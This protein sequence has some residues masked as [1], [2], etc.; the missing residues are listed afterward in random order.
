MLTE[1]LWQLL[2][3]VVFFLLAVVVLKIGDRK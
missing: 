3:V 1:A 2:G